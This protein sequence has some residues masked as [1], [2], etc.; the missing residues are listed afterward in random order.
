MNLTCAQMDVLISFYIDNELS[1]ALKKQVEEHL[2]KCPSCRAKFDIIKNMLSEI[3]SSLDIKEN[4]SDNEYKTNTHCSL[5]QYNIFKDNLSAYI[6]NEL[7]SNE[8]LKIKKFAINNNR[9]RKDLEENYSIRRLMN[10]SFKKVKS[11][12]KHDFSKNILKQLEL[13]EEA[14]SGFH[15]AIKLLIAFTITVL[16]LTSIVL[17]T[18]SV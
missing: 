12:I 2:K 10:S 3:K 18:L 7:S 13:E 11:D 15:P 14:T 9:A 1:N 17:M 6:D 8:N 4:Q 5:A 16:I